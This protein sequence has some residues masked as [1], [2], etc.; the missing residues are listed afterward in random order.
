MVD[1]SRWVA[2]TGICIVSTLFG[3]SMRQGESK[4]QGKGVD[5]VDGVQMTHH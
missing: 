1:L 3:L 5:E 2:L 4:D